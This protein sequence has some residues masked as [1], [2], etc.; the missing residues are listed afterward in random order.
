M[1]IKRV[2]KQKLIEW[3]ALSAFLMA[4]TILPSYEAIEF[5]YKKNVDLFENSALYQL[6][7]GDV[8]EQELILDN[9]DRL[10]DLRIWLSSDA[11]LENRGI[12]QVRLSQG[13]I[14]H[15]SEIDT[16]RI[17]GVEYVSSKLNLSG[18]SDGELLMAINVQ[19]LDEDASVFMRYTNEAIYGIP[20][21]R[22]NGVLCGG[23]ISL[24]YNLLQPHNHEYSASLWI[25]L[26]I[27]ITSIM[28]SYVIICTKET[29]RNGWILMAL[30]VVL[31][32]STYSLEYPARTIEGESAY[33]GPTFF[34]DNAV[35]MNVM[36]VFRQLEGGMYLS[37]IQNIIM[38]VAVRVLHLRRNLFIAVSSMS[39]LYMIMSL[40]P[41]CSHY[42]KMYFTRAFRFICALLVVYFAPINSE[43]NVTGYFGAFFLML[44][45]LYDFEEINNFIY[46][47]ILILVPIICM[48]K[49]VFVVFA[50]VALIYYI[51]HRKEMN[52]KKKACIL[53]I[54]MFSLAE[55]LLSITLRHGIQGGH[56][57]GTVQHVTL[58]A[59][60][61]KILYYTVQTLGIQI[62]CGISNSNQMLSNILDIAILIGILAFV[63]RQFIRKS[64]SYKSEAK[65][66]VTML[67][68]V[69]IQFSLIVLTTTDLHAEISWTRS[70]NAMPGQNFHF[71]AIYFAISVI[72]LTLLWVLIQFLRSH[73]EFLI[74]HAGA[75]ERLTFKILMFASV[76]VITFIYIGQ[77]PGPKTYDTANPS[78]ISSADWKSY[79]TM[80][81]SDAFCIRIE[82]KTWHYMK[83][84]SVKSIDVQRST[85]VDLSDVAELDGKTSIVAYAHKTAATNQILDRYYYMSIYDKDGNLISRIRQINSDANRLYIGFYLEEGIPNIG[86][87][88]FTYED[89]TPAFVDET[90]EIGYR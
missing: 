22:I 43:I 86:H 33:E 88:E 90:L 7:D 79:V 31:A 58:P 87:V 48:S 17:V 75:T 14:V 1:M 8:I 53:T 56:R 18:F 67:C 69:V 28:A 27:S 60:I 3:I 25:L 20:Q 19:D 15:E 52:S 63:V 65:F 32:I 37:T 4:I 34:Y 57:L 12:L 76:S 5:R 50:P 84:A 44:L 82:P 68:L 46:A 23:N 61:N 72:Y 39:T 89:G 51:L 38:L 42:F 55:G 81:D 35:S 16:S 6:K 36:S 70:L 74:E 21:A 10:D 59:L 26:V 13:E 85:S 77:R 64:A 24:N 78:R 47:L 40:A 71:L 45:L 29:S 9:G 41:F 49:M 54:G 66:I 73:Y 62:R 2:G 30:F 11:S 80:L 83:N